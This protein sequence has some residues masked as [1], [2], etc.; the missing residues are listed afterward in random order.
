MVTEIGSADLVTIVDEIFG[1]HRATFS[2]G[3]RKSLA[4]S[5][6]QPGM[7]AHEQVNRQDYDAS[8]EK[9]FR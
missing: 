6:A 4:V 7:F 2:Q 3:G 8:L 1:N 5:P 9:K